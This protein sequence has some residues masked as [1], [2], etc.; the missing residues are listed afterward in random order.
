MEKID[1]LALYIVARALALK[2]K[3]K[4][5][6]MERATQL[7]IADTEKRHNLYKY[8]VFTRLYVQ[9][10]RETLNEEASKRVISVKKKVI[11]DHRWFVYNDNSDLI[12]CFS[13]TI[14][15]IGT[16]ERTTFNNT[17]G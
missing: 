15:G 5:P 1:Q 9:G 3:S 4:R 2:H 10:E 14:H 16:R 11:L 17:Q 13:C 6:E 12:I 7:N 8:Y